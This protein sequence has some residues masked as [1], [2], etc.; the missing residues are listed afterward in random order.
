MS[1]IGPGDVVEVV[2]DC[3]GS[4]VGAVFTVGHVESMSPMWYARCN[5]CYHLMSGLD[6]ACSAPGEIVMGYE[7]FLVPIPW[8]RK[9]EPPKE[10]I[11]EINRL[12]HPNP[13]EVEA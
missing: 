1:A 11:D 2:R 10:S 13:E 4:Y 5:C 12:W 6:M 7:R 8:L 3:C 9:L